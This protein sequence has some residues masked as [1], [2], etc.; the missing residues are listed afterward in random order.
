MLNAWAPGGAVDRAPPDS[1]QP[2]KKGSLV[3]MD[4]HY[5]P[6]GGPAEI[7][8]DTKLSLMLTK[9]KPT[10][11]SRV[12]LLGNFQGTLDV[13]AG[14]GQ[15]LKQPGECKP[16]F[17]I[18]ANEKDHIEEMTWTWKLPIG[19]IRTYS[20]GTHMHFVGRG[21]R[22]TLEH[23]SSGD[24][25]CLIET[26]SW[27]YN[28]QRGYGFDAPFDQLPVMA[29]GDVLRFRCNFDNSMDNPFVVRALDQQHLDAPIDV[30]LGEN[31]LDEMCLGAI[32]I[33]YP[34]FELPPSSAD[35]G[36][37]DASSADA[38]AEDSCD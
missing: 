12:I 19:S 36:A 10:Y 31:T 18:P 24:E 3:V 21:M 25:E 33:I 20:A 1:A 2:I 6:T 14:T 37:G 29:D 32:G 8:K 5:H 17:M 15:L 4:V 35:A 13:S 11:I 27:D 23:T 16:E 30:R 34:Y 7:D 22:V 26:P 9:E 38:G 28:W